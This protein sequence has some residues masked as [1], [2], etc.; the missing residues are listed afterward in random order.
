MKFAKFVSCCSFQEGDVLERNQA[1]AQIIFARAQRR[2]RKLSLLVDCLQ[3]I[4]DQ[5]SE[6]TPKC[7]GPLLSSVIEKF[8]HLSLNEQQQWINFHQQLSEVS[9]RVAVFIQEQVYVLQVLKH[10]STGIIAALSG[11]TTVQCPKSELADLNAALVIHSQNVVKDSKIGTRYMKILCRS[12]QQ[13][14]LDEWTRQVNAD[15]NTSDG[16]WIICD[17]FLELANDVVEDL[18]A[19]VVAPNS[20][21]AIR[22]FRHDML[23]LKAK[24]SLLKNHLRC[25]HNQIIQLSRLEEKLSWTDSHSKIKELELRRHLCEHAVTFYGRCLTLLN[26]LEESFHQARAATVCAK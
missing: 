7:T 14:L 22:R 25:A 18:I 16:N 12:H 6:A 8:R 23:A 9:S 21:E 19:R 10:G 2:S 5:S 3:G 4:A 24:Q 13:D 26:R 17:T 15:L 20:P 11:M 1:K